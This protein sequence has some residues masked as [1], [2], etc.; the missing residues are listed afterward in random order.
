MSVNPFESAQKQLQEVAPFVDVDK[1]IIS[2]LM[3]PDRV[4]K[5]FLPITMD[6]GTVQVFEGYRSQHNNSAGPYKGGIR[7]HE[8]VSEGEVKALSMWM[9]WKC[10]VV[11]IPLGGGKGGVIVDPKLL[12]KAELERLSRAYARAISPI[13]GKD[14]DVPAPDVN[15]DGQIMAWMLDEY[16]QIVGR[17]EPGVITGKPLALGGSKGRTAATGRGGLFALMELAK[18]LKLEPKQTR[19]AVQGFGNVGYYF[20]KLAQAEG[21]KIVAV[22]DSKGGVFDE[23]GLDVEKLVAHKDKTGSVANYAGAQKITNA[24]LLELDV[25]VLVP[26]AF[27]NV[28]GVENA[29]NVKAKAI[30]ELANGP[31]TPAADVILHKKGIY[32]V[33]DILANAGG[34]TVSYFEWI[35]NNYGY[36]WEEEEVNQ[37]LQR[38]MSEAF[39]QVWEIHKQKNVNLRLAAYILAL[40]R[41]ADA[42]SLRG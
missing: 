16:E 11:G 25:D 14:K 23:Q 30:I 24:Q 6:D 22:S 19:V 37:K 12:S 27:E 10:A 2:R 41:V 35:Q 32:F 31:V 20:A 39:G 7:F 3:Q 29:S 9:T 26:G 17:K 5:V 13:I 33:P 1:N 18:R 38:I 34:V 36:Y 40:K 28:I 21:Y 42:I 8:D 4:L 15:T